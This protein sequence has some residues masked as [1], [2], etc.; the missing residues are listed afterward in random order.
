MITN[1]GFSGLA[2]LCVGKAIKMVSGV[3]ALFL[4]I[5]FVAVQVAASQGI[6]EVNW[7]HIES[8]VTESLDHNKDGYACL[9]RQVTVC[10]TSHA[11]LPPAPCMPTQHAAV[12]LAKYAGHNYDRNP[13]GM[14]ARAGMAFSTVCLIPCDCEQ[15]P[16]PAALPHEHER[17]CI[18]SWLSFV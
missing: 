17:R 5:A 1:L 3:V 11:D 10:C 2:G 14:H 6:I 16:W 9:I 8:I 7:S 4:G 13:F 15:L 12:Q 18:H